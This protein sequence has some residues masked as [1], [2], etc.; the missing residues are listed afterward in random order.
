MKLQI[1][2][3]I[4]LEFGPFKIPKTD[5]DVIILAGDI[6]IG[7]AAVDWIK[8]QTKKPVLY[9]AGN[10]EYYGRKNSLPRQ[11]GRASCREIGMV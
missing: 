3:D 5:A 2:S 10:H 4:H 9:V 7:T 11:I 8:S 1:L 6:H